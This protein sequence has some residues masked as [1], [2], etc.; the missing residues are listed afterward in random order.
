MYIFNSGFH[1][2]LGNYKG[3]I[4][5]CLQSKLNPRVTFLFVCRLPY[6]LKY[7]IYRR[8]EKNVIKINQFFKS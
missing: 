8:S 2:L 5:L 3:I 1:Y 6:V 4:P 7:R